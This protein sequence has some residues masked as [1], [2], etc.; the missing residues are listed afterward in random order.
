MVRM[1]V[2]YGTFVDPIIKQM[3]WVLPED[4]Q[5]ALDAWVAGSKANILERIARASGVA[6]DT[7]GLVF[8]GE[9]GGQPVEPVNFVLLVMFFV[10]LLSRDGK[11]V[12]DIM[13]EFEDYLNFVK[14]NNLDL[15]S[16]NMILA[17]ALLQLMEGTQRAIDWAAV[18]IQGLSKGGG[19]A[20]V[21]GIV[22]VAT[23]TAPITIPLFPEG[24]IP[25]R[26]RRNLIDR[27]PRDTPQSCCG[28]VHCC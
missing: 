1:G 3:K 26:L 11:N 20:I 2:L 18:A 12:F 27:S 15:Y 19:A 17:G 25:R 7:A 16:L 24:P 8:Q 21:A 14:R 23:A 28:E 10:E 6:K 13:T 5:A 9:G 22:L 4:Q